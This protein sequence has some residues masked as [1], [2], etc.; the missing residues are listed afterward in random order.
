[1][2][3]APRVAYIVSRFPSVSETF[4]LYE[5]IELSRLGATI[6]LFPLVRQHLDVAHS[7]SASWCDA[8]HWDAALD[9][10]RPKALLKWTVTILAAQLYWLVRAPLRWLRTWF[11]VIRANA[12]SAKF[13]PR[14][15][16]ATLQAA[17]F[18][19]EM[20]NLG[21]DHIHAHWATHSATA[22]FVAHELAG[23]PFSFTA[24]ANDIYVDQ[25]MLEDKIEA[26]EFL[27]TISEY[28][29]EFLRGLYG[30]VVGDNVVVIHCGVDPD[31]FA[32]SSSRSDVPDGDDASV[33][34]CVGRLT[35]KKG[36]SVLIDAL[37]E[38]GRR[39]CELACVLVGDGEDRPRLE[40]KAHDLGLGA[41]V[42]FA[43]RLGRDQ[44]A[45]RLGS[46]DVFVMPSVIDD[47]GAMEGIPVALMEAMAAGVPV[48]A[49]AVSGIPELVEDD[50]NG[51]LVPAGDAGA[52]ADAIE[53]LISDP[54]L[55]R[56]LAERGIETI[57]AEFDLAANAACLFDRIRAVRPPVGPPG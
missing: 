7:E 36:Q 28:N 34:V 15:I 26:A 43:G 40:A 49:S 30:D 11:G 39:G 22:A 21:V 2:S 47:S 41:K 25:T 1:M 8:A 44:V 4:V 24:H 35:A 46:C 23:I 37:A 38:L 9:S 27:V 17:S 16:V 13:L 53:R 31:V 51:L 33:V 48:V 52:L 6:E 10:Y 50:K 14:A 19:R 3:Q 57:H 55:G 54:R 18:A 20:R 29:R 56:D 32:A 12:H 45:L 42:E 5:M